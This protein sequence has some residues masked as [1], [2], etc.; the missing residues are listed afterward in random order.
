LY[1]QAQAKACG[2]VTDHLS[3]QD[4]AGAFTL[5]RRLKPAATYRPSFWTG[6]KPG[7]YTQAQAKACGYKLKRRL[8]PAATND[9]LAATLR[10]KLGFRLQL[11]E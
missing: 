6:Q 3:G 2:Y 9:L 4:K 10:D 11:A 5:K 1:T 7:L 8:K